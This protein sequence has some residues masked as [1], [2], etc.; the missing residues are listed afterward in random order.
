VLEVRFADLAGETYVLAGNVPY[1]ITTPIIFQGLTRQRPARAVYLVQREVAER[2]VS[3][4][5][6]REYGAISVNVQAVARAELLFRVPRGAFH[7]APKVDSAVLRII[8]RRD[9]VID[10]D[11]EEPFRA[12]VQ[13][14]F[15]FRRKQMKRVLREL[16]DVG[17][18]DAERILRDAGVDPTV[19]PETLS[20]LDFARL[21]RLRTR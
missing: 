8:P 21:L 11:E 9:P 18:D 1:Y 10:P 13:G 16:W 6:R 14:T 20:A 12:F 17:A 7:P 15:G 19:R 5:G 3:P 4:P 2:I